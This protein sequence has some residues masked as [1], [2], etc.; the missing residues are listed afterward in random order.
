MTSRENTQSCVLL[1]VMLL[2]GHEA[3][4]DVEAV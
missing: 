1:D 2:F 4:V 3:M